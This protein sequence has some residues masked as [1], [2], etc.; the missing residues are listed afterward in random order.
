MVIS[1]DA[2]CFEKGLHSGHCE[3]Q[4]RDNGQQNEG[5]YCLCEYL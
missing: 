3:G 2:I 5:R 4:I 1:L